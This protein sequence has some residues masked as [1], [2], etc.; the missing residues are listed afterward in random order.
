MKHSVPAVEHGPANLFPMPLEI[1]QSINS[2]Q[3]FASMEN[4]EG[5]I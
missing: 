3:S 2:G 4:K 1:F 5:K